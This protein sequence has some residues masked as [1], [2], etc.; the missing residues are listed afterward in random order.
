MSKRQTAGIVGGL[1]GGAAAVVG[2]GIAI[3]RVVIGRAGRRSDVHAAE[4]L[5]G[6]MPDRERTVKTDDGVRLHIEE[7]GP[8]S[9]PLTVVFVHGYTL[10]LGAFHFQRKALRTEFGGRL[11]LVLFDQRSHG[12]SGRSDRGHATLP[13]LARDLGRIIQDIAGPIVLVGHSMGGMSIIEL[14]AEHPELFGGPVVAA[15]LISTSSGSLSGVTLGLPGPLGRAAG[16]IAPTVIGVA[17]RAP[18]L[19]E[20]GRRLGTDLAWFITNRMSFGS[21]PVSPAVAEYLNQMI[22]ATPITVVAD[23]YPAIMSHERRSALAAM[24]QCPVAVVCGSMDRL[25]P[26]PHSELIA[27]EI[28]GAQLHVIKDAGHVVVLERPDEVNA[29]LVELVREALA[30]QAAGRR[31]A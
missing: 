8:E 22:A 2:T 28:P 1:L 6:L 4:N 25:T 17:A 5:G 21:R 20:S 9:A 18:W 19:V 24:G 7:D 14:A 26:L 3:E 10:A 13:Q 11:R 16:A 23:F 12:R 15:M 27:S 30:H 29:I 31:R